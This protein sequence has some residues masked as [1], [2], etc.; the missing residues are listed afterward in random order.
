MRATRQWIFVLHVAWLVGAG[1]VALAQQAKPRAPYIP[2]PK[3]EVSWAR[4]VGDQQRQL[5]NQ[6]CRVCFIGDSLT[7]FWT[8]HGRD[9]W[10]SQFAPLKAT[11][12]GLAADRTEHVLNRIHRLE[13]RRANPKLIVLMMGTN[14]LGMDPPDQPE[15]VARAVKDGV[16]LLRAKLPQASV[17]I[18]TLPPN[19]HQP[20]SVTNQRIRQTNALLLQ[21]SWPAYAR[22]LQ[23][24]DAMVDDRGRWRANY[25][26][27]GTHF[28]ETGY[29]KLGELLAPVVKEMLKEKG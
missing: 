8:H 13:F 9:T 19:G 5:A 3:A 10:A 1:D 25:T 18:L 28:S 17:L 20:D 15:D 6:P 7:Q 21:H 4:D 11:N 29:A 16:N 2:E 27:D 12:L 24:H 22:V 14:N 23:I 26:L